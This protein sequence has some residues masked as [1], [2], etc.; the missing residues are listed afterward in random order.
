MSTPAPYG[1]VVAEHFRRPRNRGTL[2]SPDASAEAVNPLC[3]DR[4]RIE[5][6]LDSGRQRIVETRFSADACAICVAAA[7][8][9]TERLRGMV[10]SDIL[11]LSDDDALSQLHAEIPQARQRC[12]TLPLA[13]ARQALS[14]SRIQ[15]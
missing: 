10:A 2:L 1:T 9:L 7:S 5:L 4:V 6:R 14:S 12:A 8:V 13:A 11:A 15:S 3:G